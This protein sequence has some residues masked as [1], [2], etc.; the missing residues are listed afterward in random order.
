M[1]YG[2]LSDIHSNLEALNAVLKEFKEEQ[3]EKNI[4][5]GDIVGYGANPNEC[6]E[7]IRN[8]NFESVAG[9][10]DLAVIGRQDIEHFNPIAKESM[11]WTAD[12]L[13]TDNREY[14][15]QLELKK[16]FP[17]FVI[18]HSTILE[19]EEW[20]YVRTTLEAHRNFKELTKPVCFFSHSHIPIVFKEK[21]RPEFSF[22]TSI[23]I[24]ENIKYLI[25]VGSVGQ[26]RD[27]NPK[28]CYAIYDTEE[29][30]V[31]IKRVSYDI[32]T[33]QNKIREADLPRM[34]A[35]RLET[36]E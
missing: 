32:K 2:L 6:V 15:K 27:K 29:K 21:E 36:G 17:G 12:T 9:N 35:Y 31:E 20:K 13:T 14:L 5:I 8:N 11:I 23:N 26:P 1:K 16:E 3:V 4:C 19:P 10:H 22:D 25:N 24:E 30:K 33:A 28:A 18:V 34:S 7:L